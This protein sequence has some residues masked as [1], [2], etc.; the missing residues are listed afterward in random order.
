MWVGG[1]STLDSSFSI[2]YCR[3]N[4]IFKLQTTILMLSLK[5]FLSGI[6]K[7]FWMWLQSVVVYSCMR[8][9]ETRIYHRDSGLKGPDWLLRFLN[10]SAIRDK[11]IMIFVD[12]EK[13]PLFS[14]SLWKSFLHWNKQIRD[15]TA[16][17]LLCRLCTVY[18][19]IQIKYRRR[20]MG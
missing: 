17:N 1:S 19:I 16:E 12:D 3:D 20:R 5:H 11:L 7:A 6:N 2:T 15:Q 8:K 10:V 13:L 4:K 9:W 14:C 18:E